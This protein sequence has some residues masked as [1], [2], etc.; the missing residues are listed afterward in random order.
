MKL[1]K[2]QRVLHFFYL[3]LLSVNTAY[4]CSV[5]CTQFVING[6]T[7]VS[8]KSTEH[9]QSVRRQFRIASWALFILNIFYHLS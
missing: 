7:V 2:V 1:N 8:S 6:L 3:Y 9:T 5:E 4:L